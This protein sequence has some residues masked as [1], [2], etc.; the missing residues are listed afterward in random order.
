MSMCGI[1]SPSWVPSKA[2]GQNYLVNEGIVHKI[3]DAIESNARHIIEIGP[4]RG[5]LTKEFLSRGFRVTGI[6]LHHETAQVLRKELTNENFTLLETDATKINYAQLLQ[7]SQDVIVGNLPYCVAA[8][9]LFQLFRTGQSAARW[10]LMFQREV[11]MRIISSCNTREYGQLS[12]VSQ[13]TTIPSIAFHVQPGSFMPS[14]DV[15]STVVIFKPLDKTLPWDE[16]SNW[17]TKVFSMR[18]KQMG[19]ILSTLIPLIEPRKLAEICHF[20]LQNRPEQL[21]PEVHL[22]L[23]QEVFYDNLSE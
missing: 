4:G 9:I 8:R 22:H 3:A 18:R 11:A 5:A 10:I 21:P 19:R 14:P 12:I 17:L 20:D 16:L 15:V 13:L 2:W 1:D 23:F 7:S 6:E